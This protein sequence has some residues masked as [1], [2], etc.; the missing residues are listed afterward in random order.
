M[1]QFPVG[2]D[3]VQETARLWRGASDPSPKLRVESVKI[4]ASGTATI[5][6]GGFSFRVSL[7]QLE[8]LGLAL[9]G[10]GDDLDGQA[11]AA[12]RLAA[13]AHE[14]ERRALA[15]LARAEQSSFLLRA[16][17][18]AR[19]FG[20]QALRMA[21]E[22]LAA[23]GFLDD[24]R[25]AR[26]YAAS[27]L[28][29]RADGPRSLEA[30]LRGRGIDRDLAG[31]VSAAAF[32]GEERSRFLARAAE[33]ELRRAKGDREDARRRLRTLGFTSAEITEL[34]ERKE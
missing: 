22:R 33:R 23:S 6:A 5:G 30:A 4:E 11:E 24:R 9:P 13:E 27:R 14:A 12:L 25:Y 29:R 18:E 7:A 8:E 32:E 17:L 28:A 3:D 2:D 26:A 34:F 1:K 21:L 10:P 16:K 20:P 31:E 19:G 15:L